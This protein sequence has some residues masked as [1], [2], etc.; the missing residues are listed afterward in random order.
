MAISTPGIGSNLDVNSIVSQL[1][2]IE[3][4]PL[5]RLD[6]KEASYQAKLSAYGGVRS[7]L[8]TF[9]DAVDSLATGTKFVTRSATSTDT[10]VATASAKSNAQ[11]GTYSLDVSQLAQ[12][13]VLA[14]A[15]QANS[16]DAIGSGVSTELRFEFGT[17]SGGTL[18]SG[19]YSGASFASNAQS[20]TGVVTI[21]PTNNSLSGIKDAIN[22]A[23]IGVRASIVGDGSANPYRLVLQSASSGAAGSM[24]I[25]VSGDSALESLLSYDPAGTQNLTQ[26]VEAQ[27]AEL[28]INGLAIASSSN[29]LS[30]AIEGATVSLLKAGTTT[31]TVSRDT[32]GVQSA[33]QDF[34]DA[35]N[36]LSKTLTGVSA[37]DV[38]AG[39]KAALN[40]DSAVRTIQ[41]Q[42]RAALSGSL[43]SNFALNT[44]SQ[45]GIGFQRDGTLQLD[46]G[47]LSDA[48][49]SNADDVSA[50]FAES[51]RSTDSFVSVSKQTSRTQAG[52]YEL[53]VTALGT[54]GRIEGSAAANLTIEEGTNDTLN[55]ALDDLTASVKLT[56]GTYTAASLAA[57]VQSAI[58]GASA[59][60]AAS[61]GVT[62]TQDAG[63]FTILSNR[64]GA[65]SSVGLGGNGAL[66]LLGDFPLS[67]QGVDVAG[68]IGGVEATG[69]GRLLTG[70]DGSV[71]QGLELEIT[72]GSVGARG[73]VTV[74]S[75]FA[76]RL[77]SLIDGFLDGDGTLASRTE[78]VNR[79]IDDID[80]LRDT[81]NRR[82]QDTETRYRAQFTALDVMMTN[83]LQT[84]NYLTQQLSALNNSKG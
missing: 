43:G 35:Y 17:I 59:F 83:M 76:A 53:T 48:L 28:T 79:S 24:K 1:M 73:N 62:V 47:K 40:G 68:T 81:L 8:S 39:T 63:I 77:S 4:Q 27:D 72:G 14:A 66:D 70:A 50:L 84:S 21:D 12:S 36:E 45:I 5:D 52:T 56:A 31:V 16:T 33:V 2:A 71:T 22:A 25:S 58:N 23:G 54:Q 78:G 20:T 55:V 41:S 67:S 69:S 57:M 18:T 42:L 34:V 44:L 61:R 74:G 32:S 51:G 30:D 9:Q 46:T 3:R 80:R 29:S 75:G 38:K 7:A 13:H 37:A 15:G 60:S 65:D 26:T 11:T 64:Y 82:L 10:A 49:E 6:V 19:V